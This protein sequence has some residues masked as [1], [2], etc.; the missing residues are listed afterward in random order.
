MTI[1][2]IIRSEFTRAK[3]DALATFSENVAVK[4]TVGK[5]GAVA[6]ESELVRRLTMEYRTALTEA[7]G[8]DKAKTI[9]LN[10]VQEQLVAALKTLATLIELQPEASELYYVEAGFSVTA[11]KKSSNNKTQLDTPQ[12]L[13]SMST[14]IKGELR[15][16]FEEI[17]DSGFRKFSLEYSADQGATWQNGTYTG[18]RKFLYANLPSSADLLLRA[19]AIGTHDRLSPWSAVVSSAVL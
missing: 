14:G 9:I 2:K 12:I 13:K 11:E 1:V 3:R 7:N 6:K 18:R 10:D 19:R 5:Y 16:E 4:T 8:G 15:M 17:K